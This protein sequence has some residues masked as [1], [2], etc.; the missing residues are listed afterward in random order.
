MS[1]PHLAA[2]FFDPERYD[3]CHRVTAS[4][5]AAYPPSTAR[6]LISCVHLCDVRL[7]AEPHHG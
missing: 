2:G 6:N 7:T 3:E 4:V 1:D 5:I